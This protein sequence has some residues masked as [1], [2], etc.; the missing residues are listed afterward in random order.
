MFLRILAQCVW[1]VAKRGQKTRDVGTD[2]VPDDVFLQ[3]QLRV[4]DTV[5]RS[6]YLAQLNLQVRR[7]SFDGN[8]GCRL[9]DQFN[10]VKG[11]VAYVIFDDERI[12]VQSLGVRKH[13]SAETNRVLWM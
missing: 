9:S 2:D 12:L 13:L 1:R 3:P 6:D 8:T 5:A 10:I 7:A 11:G 4:R